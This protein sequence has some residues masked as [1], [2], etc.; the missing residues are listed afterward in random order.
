M[1]GTVANANRILEE[2]GLQVT[3]ADYGKAV[4]VTNIVCDPITRNVRRL[5]FYRPSL[6]T[7]TDPGKAR[8]LAFDPQNQGGFVAVARTPYG[9]QIIVLG[10]SLWWN[11]IHEYRH[12]SDNFA[13]M[14]NLLA[15]AVAKTP[16]DK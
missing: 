9:G 5:E 1:R 6:I 12:R 8:I 13:L 14:S 4:T 7:V 15:H 11:W 3:D 2:Y 10:T 16:S